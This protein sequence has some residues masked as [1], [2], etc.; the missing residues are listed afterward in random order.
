M[1]PP[2]IRSTQ[3]VLA[4]L[5]AGLLAFAGVTTFVRLGMGPIE[6]SDTLA[7]LTIGVPVVFVVSAGTYAVLR[8][9]ML[10]P[11]LAD[12]EAALA[13]VREERLPP[14][15]QRA[16]I[17]GAAL[18]EGPGLLGTAVVLLGGPW[19]LIATPFVSIAWIVLL[20]PTRERVESIV[21]EAR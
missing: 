16:T 21:R 10:A 3:I 1:Q 7:A 19:L 5:I 6:S 15:L 2:T 17:V 18:A 20:M 8:R 13:L 9:P 12:R 11:V 4:A 14:A